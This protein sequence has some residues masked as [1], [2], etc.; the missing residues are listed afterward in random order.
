MWAAALRVRLRV[1]DT[2]SLKRKR[3]VLRPHVERL[4][5]MMSVSVAEVDEHDAWQRA[6]LGLALVAVDRRALESLIDRV[7]RYFDGQS[8]I[9]LIEIAVS[10]LENPE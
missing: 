2:R 8:D 9:E 1:L 6:T 10:Y 3:S 7:R 4:K 5:A